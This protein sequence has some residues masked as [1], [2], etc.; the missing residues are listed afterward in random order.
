MALDKT[1]DAFVE[2]FLPPP[3]RGVC[4]VTADIIKKS[5]NSIDWSEGP[6]DSDTMVEVSNGDMEMEDQEVPDD[7]SDVDSEDVDSEDDED[8]ESENDQ[9]VEMGGC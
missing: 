8:M 9:G 2:S 5:A 1:I 7:N 6:D 3:G 4:T